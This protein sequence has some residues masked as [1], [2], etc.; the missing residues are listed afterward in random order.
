MSETKKKS[1]AKAKKSEPKSKTV[2]GTL[3]AAAE[4]KTLKEAPDTSDSGSVDSGSANYSIGEGQK[5]VTKAY[6]KGWDAI[7]STKR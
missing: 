6:R 3:E 1:T 7:F 2:K 5:T 4:A